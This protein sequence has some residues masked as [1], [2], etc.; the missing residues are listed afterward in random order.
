MI[1]VRSRL[2]MR[3]VS[4]DSLK[5]QIS[6]WRRGLYGGISLIL[7]AGLLSGWSDI[8]FTGVNAGLVFYLLMIIVSLSVAGWNTVTQVDRRR[9]VIGVSRRLFGVRVAQKEFLFPDLQEILIRKIV[10]FR[11][12]RQQGGTEYAR[13]GMLTPG[14]NALS[15]RRKE[16]GKLYLI[17]KSQKPEFLEESTDV[18]DLWSIGESISEFC[19][20]PVRSEEI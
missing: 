9:G 3:K 7:L 17:S 19:G 8:P 15:P 11:G 4:E 14:R 13:G 20:L 5:M 10:L 1:S 16:L 2:S 18:A 12:F 6:P